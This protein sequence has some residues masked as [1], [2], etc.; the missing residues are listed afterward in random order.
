MKLQLA[1]TIQNAC[2][3]LMVNHNAV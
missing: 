2:E 3:L 1:S